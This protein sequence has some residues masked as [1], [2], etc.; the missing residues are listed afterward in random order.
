MSIEVPE[1]VIPKYAGACVSRLIPALVGGED[2][3]W[4]PEIATSAQSVI[5]L[6]VDGL[7]SDALSRHGSELP[8]L[9]AMQGRSIT[10]VAPSTTAA[11]LTSIATGFAPAIHGLVGYRLMVPDGVLNVLSWKLE[12]KR[13]PPSPADIQLRSPFLGR[14]VPVVTKEH[15]RSTGFTE[16]HLRGTDLQGWKVT[17]TLVERLRI[18][19][20]AGEKFIYAYYDGIDAV[21]HEF[22]LHSNYYLSELKAADALVAQIIDVIP[23]RTALLI[24]ADHGQVHVGPSGWLSVGSI[25]SLVAHQAGD[26]RFRYLFARPGAARELVEESKRLYGDRAWVLGREELIESGWLGPTPPSG[27]VRRR[28]GDVVLAAR[29]PVAFADP[30]LPN[31]A[32]LI[33]AHGSLTAAEMFVPLI[34]AR[35]RAS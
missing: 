34:A 16:A 29:D 6:V 24:T 32:K 5:L 7:G 4:I 2:A 13:R 20:A 14:T 15:F 22:G 9:S 3:S 17:S 33:S 35:G 27:A 23:E 19:S 31:E 12:S 1:P 8:T 30:A 11:A 28:L 18:L 25:S 26:A 10:T 21:A